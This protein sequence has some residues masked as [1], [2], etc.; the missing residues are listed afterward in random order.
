MMR[1]MNRFPVKLQRRAAPLFLAVALLGVGPAAGAGQMGGQDLTLVDRVV[2]VVGDSVVLQTQIQ[3]EIQRLRLQGR[4]IPTDPVGQ[5]QFFREVLDS[6]VNRLMVLQAAAKDT[7][8]SVDEELVQERVAEEIR[9]RSE[10]IGG[11]QAFQEALLAEG[12]TLA[13]YREILSTE[14]RQSQ[15]QQM[16][17]QRRIQTAPPV[18]VTEEELRQAFEQA[19]GRLEERP[20]LITF[21]QVVIKPEPSDSAKARAR[22]KLQAILDSINAGADFA[23]MATRYSQDP[24]TAPNGGDLGWFRR[25]QMVRA[26]EDA[27]FDLLDGQI[28]PIVETDFGYHIIKVERSRAGERKARHILIIPEESPDDIERARE[29]AESIV[30]QARAG[31]PMERL[32]ERFSDPNAPDSLTVT[33]D[34]LS[35]LPPG[36]DRLAGAAA[37]DVVGPIEYQTGRN[38]TRIAVVKIKEVREAG[39]YTLDDVRDQL[40]Q[41][42]TQRKQYE[43]IL[44]ELRRRTY[45]EI[46][47]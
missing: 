35:D 15:L 31:V 18:V 30:V 6:W 7:L 17:M 5:E 14:L 42:I 34:Q 40:Q 1:R 3:E 4:E 8:I 29:L 46:R 43:R 22:A 9:N 13:E 12:M 24:G 28:S 16:Y 36:Y 26:F 27:A 19:K 38:E 39:A 11:Q 23:E 10:Q 41:Q 2:A 37:G 33:A 21:E 25:G 44:E 45:I 47:I 20:S 32:Y